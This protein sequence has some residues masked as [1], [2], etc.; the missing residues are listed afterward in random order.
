MF[1][2]GEN[3]RKLRKTAGLTQI[4]FAKQIG[5]SQGTLSDIEQGNCNPSVDT[6]LSIHNH[7]NVTLDWLLKGKQNRSTIEQVNALD[8]SETEIRV[9]EVMNQLDIFE[10]QRVLAFA[11]FTLNQK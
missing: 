8:L 10:K 1:S 9:L 7:F 4:E 11:S 6:A 2:I 3:I 5:I